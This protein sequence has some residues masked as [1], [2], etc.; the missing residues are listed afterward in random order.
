MIRNVRLQKVRLGVMALLGAVFL[1]L[2]LVTQ[3]EATGPYCQDLRIP[4]A[5]APGLPKNHELA[6]T[7]CV[8]GKHNKQKGQIDILVHGAG[9]NRSYWDF[10][11]SSPDYSYVARANAAKRATFAYDRLGA[12]E[13]SRPLS[14]QVTIDTDS[15]GLRQVIDYLRDE[16]NFKK[17]AVVGHSFG[18]MVAVH[19]A[20]T[21]GGLDK[22]VLTGLLHAFG[23]AVTQGELQ[24][25]PAVFDPQFAGQGYDPGWLTTVPGVRPQVFYHATAAAAV[26]AYDEAHK[27]VLSATQ[28]A[29][30]ITQLSAPAALNVSNGITVPTLLVNGE[31]D[32]L[33][34][35]GLQLDCT[36]HAAVRN[37][38][39]PYFTNA[40]SFTVR[41]IDDTGH[42]LPLHPSAAQSSR[43]IHEW[44][45]C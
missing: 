42:N 25:Y 5:L 9:Y 6:G 12:G 33:Y 22:L 35:G 19:E 32:R 39:A 18:S 43:V 20:A 10:P 38:E 37:F 24:N 13:S 3:V 16:K 29:D 26:T 7:L 23:P 36:N 40:T 41:M 14:S 11:V 2:G 30:G 45:R 27:D 4:V 34:C 31:Y 8:P 21:Y 44:L 28:L 17:V 15:Y 1:S